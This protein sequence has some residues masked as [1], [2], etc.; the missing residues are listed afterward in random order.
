MADLKPLWTN[1]PVPT[2]GLE[3]DLAVQR[4]KDPNAYGNPGPDG[5]APIWTNDFVPTPGGEETPN[6]VSGL[7]AHIDR[8]APSG[9]PPE[10]PNLTDRSPGTIDEQ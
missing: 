5:L 7:P 4:G 9:T 10:P 1:P 3:G 2:P 8:Y 6:S